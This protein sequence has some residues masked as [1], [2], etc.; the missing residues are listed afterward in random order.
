[1]DLDSFEALSEYLDEPH[2]IKPRL[3]LHACCAPCSTYV[4]EYL[5]DAFDITIF[6]YNPNIYPEEEY[7]KRKEEFAKLGKYPLIEGPYTPDSFYE[8]ILG[9]EELPEG[10]HRCFTCYRI[11]LEETAKVA[12]QGG[13]DYFTTTLSISPYKNSDKLNE[14]GQE[15]AKEY[16]VPFVYSNFK[17]NDGYKKSIA[18]CREM[19]IYRQHYCGCVFSY[20]DMKRRV[21]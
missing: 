6:Y 18:L 20:E 7:L 9:M 5:C 8:D 2:E 13:F 17:K 14:I 10:S 16:G 21:T 11:R 12:I 15:L 4:L 3:L 19:G 1:M